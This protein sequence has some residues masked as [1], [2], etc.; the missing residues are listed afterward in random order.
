MGAQSARQEGRTQ[1]DLTGEL[2]S[3]AGKRRQFADAFPIK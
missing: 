1:T 2:F 3:A